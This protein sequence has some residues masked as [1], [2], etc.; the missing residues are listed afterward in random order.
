MTE[1]IETIKTIFRICKMGARNGNDD[2]DASMCAKCK[3]MVLE[4]YKYENPFVTAT[5]CG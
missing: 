2:D 1:T 4:C 5:V 3:V